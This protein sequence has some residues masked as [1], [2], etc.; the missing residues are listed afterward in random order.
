M[1]R[2][3][4]PEVLLLA[5]LMVEVGTALNLGSVGVLVCSYV[6]ETMISVHEID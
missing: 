5:G 1:P 2:K 6:A 4:A 3:D